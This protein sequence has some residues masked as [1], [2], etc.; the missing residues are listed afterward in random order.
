M[1]CSGDGFSEDVELDLIGVAVEMETMTTDEIIIIYY[2]VE[3][4]VFGH[5]PWI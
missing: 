3:N 5:D 2:Y 1:S 4:C